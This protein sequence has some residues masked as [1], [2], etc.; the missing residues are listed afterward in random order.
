MNKE[1]S[2]I[3]THCA[4]AATQ[5]ELDIVAA[6]AIKLYL[7]KHGENAVQ[8]FNVIVDLFSDALKSRT[9]SMTNLAKEQLTNLFEGLSAAGEQ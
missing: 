8:S 9:E 7:E 2:V 1:L 5:K 4:N 6:L 3:F